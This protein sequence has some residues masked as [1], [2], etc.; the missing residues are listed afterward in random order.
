[1]SDALTLDDVHTYYGESHVLQGMALHVDAGQIVS[2]LGRNGVGKTTTLRT[3]MGLTPPRRGS[4]AYAGQP[5][6][7]LPPHRIARLG[8]QLVP[9]DRGIFPHLTVQENL[10]VGAVRPSDRERAA[11]NAQRIFEYFP[12][13]RERLRQKGGSLSGGEQQQLTIARA[14]MSGPALL[15]LDEPCEGLA[16]L[17]VQTLLDAIR[18][19]RAAGTTVL[20]VEQN[21]HA[22]LQVAEQHYVMDR[23]RV[24]GRFSSDE[25]L[26][27]EDLRLRF[28]GV[29]AR[30]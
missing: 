17:V 12:V 18:E 4:I 5:I 16:P 13:L 23:G 28:L 24:I 11:Q 21:V 9:E 19:I 8:I 3:I 2:L 15:L 29:S 20:L 14:L 25:L 1:M 22:A 6:Q 27:D 7:G 26:A 30:L 10:R